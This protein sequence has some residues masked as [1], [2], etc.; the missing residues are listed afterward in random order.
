[1]KFVL[2]RVCRFGGDHRYSWV[3][4]ARLAL[5]AARERGGPLPSIDLADALLDERLR[6]DRMGYNP[7][8]GEFSQFLASGPVVVRPDAEY[9]ADRPLARR[10]PSTPRPARRGHGSRDV[11]AARRPPRRT[12]GMSRLCDRLGMST[13][14]DRRASRQAGGDGRAGSSAVAA[15]SAGRDG[16]TA[17][18][19]QDEF[20]SR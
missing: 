20:R 11:E 7:P 6:A 3:V 15:S 2:Q 18:P 10:A 19:A 12:P 13:A 1:M 14:G 4:S 8:G 9:G 5:V 17:S 16:S